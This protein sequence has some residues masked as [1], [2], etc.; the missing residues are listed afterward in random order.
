MPHEFQPGDLLV[1]DAYYSVY[2]L[3]ASLAARNAHYVGDLS[4]TRKADYRTGRRLDVFEVGEQP[5]EPML[6]LG[7][8]KFG[9]QL[10]GGGE[11]DTQADAA[12]GK[13]ARDRHMRLPGPE[14]P[15][16]Q[17]LVC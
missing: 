14:P 11:L 8:F 1:G 16:K 12:K 15:I 9:D 7:G 2:W 3:L 4:S 17:A 13:S 6:L 10:R 5:V